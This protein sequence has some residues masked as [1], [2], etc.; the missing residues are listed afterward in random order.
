MVSYFDFTS[1]KNIVPIY[2]A[3]DKVAYFFTHEK[4][5]YNDNVVTGFTLRN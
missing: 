2:Q 4:E 1:A 5:V 3:F